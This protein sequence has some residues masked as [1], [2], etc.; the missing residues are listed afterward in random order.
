MKLKIKK[1]FILLGIACLLIMGFSFFR[2]VNSPEKETMRY[3]GANREILQENVLCYETTGQISNELDVK[4]TYW[5]GE[6]P[7]IE[8]TMA[9]KGL[10][11]SSR[12][13]GFFYSFDD[14][15]VS[16]QNANDLLI[17]ISDK[18]WE[19]KGKGDNKGIVRKIESNWFYF[20]TSF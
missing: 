8:Y 9:T 2:M 1:V 4:A 16:F 12:Y 20:E 7:I 18:E 17:P 13:Y 6:H 19:W 15:P 3:F 14:V 5:N 11:P 10:L